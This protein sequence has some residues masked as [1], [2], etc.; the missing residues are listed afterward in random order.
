MDEELAK[1]IRPAHGDRKPAALTGVAAPAAVATPLSAAIWF[2]LNIA[3]SVGMVLL[4]KSLSVGV[5]H[6]NTVLG[7]QNGATVAYLII[8]GRTCGLFDLS[9][10]FRPAQFTPFVAPIVNWVVMLALSLKML[11][12]NSVATATMFKTLGT[13]L[14]C[15]I[16]VLYFKARYSRRAQAS[17]GLLGLGSAVYAGTDVGFS[18][19]GYLFA[20]LQI[21]SWVLQTFIDKATIVDSEQTKAGITVIRNLLSLPVVCLLINLSGEAADAVPTVLLARREVWGQILLSSVCGCGL[22][23]TTSA[24]YQHFAPTTVVVA[25]NVGKCLSIALGCALFRDRLSP[26]QVLGLATSL[27]GSFLYGREERKRLALP[28]PG[29]AAAAK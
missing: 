7:L 17:L 13:L 4:N 1:D 9:V 21:S 11:Q 20:S 28:A 5:G 19:V 6:P 8:G 25:N 24:L 16:E 29:A 3:C 18:P 14:T 10:P 26:L 27:A 22:G 23:L 12:Y 2:P 15:A